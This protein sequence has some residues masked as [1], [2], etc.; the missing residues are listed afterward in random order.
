[1]EINIV[2]FLKKVLYENQGKTS[3]AYSWGTYSSHPYVLLNYTDTLNDMFTLAHE[4]GHSLH[5][6]FSSETQEYIYSQYP[7][8]LAEV[9]STFNE[10]LLQSY[11]EKITE[12]KMELAYL[13]DNLINSFKGTVFR[14][15]MFAEFEMLAHEMAENNQALTVDA[16]KKMYRDLNIKYFGDSVEIDEQIEYEWSRIPHFY[17][18]FYVY[19]YATGFTSAVALAK[20]VLENNTLDSYIEFF[21]SG[22][23]KYPL[24]TRKLAGIDLSTNEPIKDALEVFKDTVDKFESIM[25]K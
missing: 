14:Q 21:A 5:S 19:K 15:T 2:I 18:S 11:L 9:A 4:M 23:R 16:L 3:G 22:G 24:Y 13:Y 10:S 20:N 6:Y 17:R 7:I 25:L 12:D 1:M 8:F